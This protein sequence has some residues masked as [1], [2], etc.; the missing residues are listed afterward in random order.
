MYTLEDFMA[1]FYPL[2]RIIGGTIKNEQLPSFLS[3]VN[4]CVLLKK[5]IK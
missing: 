2:L 1:S 3:E 5:R 4:I